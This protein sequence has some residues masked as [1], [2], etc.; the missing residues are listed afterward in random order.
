MCTISATAAR[1]AHVSVLLMEVFEPQQSSPRLRS[2]FGAT[3]TRPGSAVPLACPVRHVIDTRARTRFFVYCMRVTTSITA[4][5]TCCLL[6]RRG[7]QELAPRV[8]LDRY[9][10]PQASSHAADRW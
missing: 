1:D 3:R 5:D 10:A 8:S 7:P 4:S 9:R 6:R 2:R